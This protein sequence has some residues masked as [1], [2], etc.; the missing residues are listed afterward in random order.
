MDKNKGKMD[1]FRGEELGSVSYGAYEGVQKML[2]EMPLT[3]TIIKSLLA[4]N[5][6]PP[7]QSFLEPVREYF[8][9]P[10]LDL[11]TPT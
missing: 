7:V 2:M 10:D 1:Q 11:W 6:S 4:Q 8:I 9:D 5:L 3:Q